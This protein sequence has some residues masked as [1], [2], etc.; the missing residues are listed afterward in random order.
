MTESEHHDTPASPARP[1][2]RRRLFGLALT[3]LALI[4]L[5][6]VVVYGALATGG[7]LRAVAALAQWAVPALK[8]EVASGSL[9]R[10]PRL[11]RLGYD[12]GSLYVDA[13]GV[14]LDWQVSGLFG[15]RLDVARLHVNE[16]RFASAPSDA[17]PEVPA[18]LELPLALSARLSVGRFVL[19]DPAAHDTDTL[20][21]QDLHATVESDGNAHRLDDL[22]LRPPG[23]RRAVRCR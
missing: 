7:G 8:L 3:D 4:A 12:D 10:S 16:L 6:V 1:A 18:S 11:S 13:R 5:P 17:P 22:G 15:G 20:V 19:A 21:L 23:A 14:E 9:I 2:R